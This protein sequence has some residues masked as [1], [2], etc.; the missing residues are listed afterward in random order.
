MEVVLLEPLPGQRPRDAGQI[1]VAGF[2]GHDDILGNAVIVIAA[3]RVFR[4]PPYPV[5]AR[6][7]LQGIIDQVAQAQAN[8]VRLGDGPEGRPVG[9]NVG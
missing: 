9:V 7:R 5:K 6:P 8:V 1:L 4:M 3:D 2:A